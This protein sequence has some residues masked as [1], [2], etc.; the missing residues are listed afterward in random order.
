MN[1]LRR[2]FGAVALAAPLLLTVTT[3][4]V[5][6]PLPHV[7]VLVVEGSGTISPGVGLIPGPQSISFD[8][9][10]TVVGTDGVLV[11]Y[12][13]SFSG[14]D[15]AGSTAAGSGTVSGSCG[16]I[17]LSL[18]IFVRVGSVV[19]VICAEVQV[20]VHV[21]TAVA[22]CVFRPHDTLPTTS[23]DLICEATVTLV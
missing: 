11:T 13:C 22:E 8:G 19:I 16:P 7:D 14:T 10:A 21:G 17:S 1:L 9:T 20:G 15:P 3:P 4:A 12:D 5:A 18:C 6:H 23:Y 2:T